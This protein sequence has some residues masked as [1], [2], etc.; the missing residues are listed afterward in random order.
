[1]SLVP[2]LYGKPW[3]KREYLIVLNAYFLNV[4]EPRHVGVAYVQK[5]AQIIGRT[6]ASVVMRLENFASL[7]TSVSD[8]RSGL[9]H[10]NSLGKRLFA[11]YVSKKDA[12]K[13]LASFLVQENREKAEPTLFEP[14]PI[15]L[16]RAFQKYELMDGL[17]EGGSGA[18]FSC[19]EANSGQRFAIKIIRTDRIYDTESLSRF[20]REIRVLKSIR[21]HNVIQLHDDNLDSQRDFPAYVM[22]FAQCSL[23]SL[24][25]ERGSSGTRLSPDEAYEAVTSVMNGIEALHNNSPAII[26]RDINPHNVLKLTNGSWVL[27]DFGLAKFTSTMPV[28]TGFQTCTQRGPGTAWYAAPEQYRNFLETDVRTDIYGVGMLLWEVFSTSSPPPSKEDHGLPDS[29]LA[30]FLKATQRNPDLRYTNIADMK[31]AFDLAFDHSFSDK[32][33]RSEATSK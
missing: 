18:V 6:P 7:D 15:Q 8:F 33:W 28:S 3:T 29:L 32:N 11:E 26:H 5:V 4:G 30:I 16:P 1:M 17:G 24:L 27:A 2:E 12:L 20:R 25:H 22:D 21:H 31:A 14:N 10:I 13:E 19:V 9:T 23:A